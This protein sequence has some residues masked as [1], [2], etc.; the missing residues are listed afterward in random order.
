MHTFINSLTIHDLLADMEHQ[1]KLNK[2]KLL[3]K[4]NT[5]T[6]SCRDTYTINLTLL[7]NLIL[8]N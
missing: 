5:L 8:N 6:R 7:S 3:I 4:E 1:I 2:N